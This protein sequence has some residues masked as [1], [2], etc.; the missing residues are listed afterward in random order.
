MKAYAPFSKSVQA[1]ISPKREKLGQGIAVPAE[2]SE[3]TVPEGQ[4]V[5]D[6]AW[7]RMTRSVQRATG[8]DGMLQGCGELM[9]QKKLNVGDQ[10]IQRK[11]TK[12]EVSDQAKLLHEAVDIPNQDEVTEREKTV[13]FQKKYFAALTTP[14]IDVFE[15]A[16]SMTQ[17]YR[18]IGNKIPYKSFL[19]YHT[20]IKKVS[21]FKSGQKEEFENKNKDYQE[22]TDKSQLVEEY[23]NKDFVELTDPFLVQI[24]GQYKGK[25]DAHNLLIL[26]N[27]CEGQKGYIVGVLDSGK[28]FK[29][30][31][32]DEKKDQEILGQGKGISRYYGNIHLI[33]SKKILRKK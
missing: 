14:K 2:K 21:N 29:A 30:E 6:N 19:T 13:K 16:R 7:G 22:K 31:M 32:K 5:A 12:P 18:E 8:V 24:E 23:R 25:G 11:E 33:A 20:L 15:A 3:A 9:V 27:Y 10:A 17:V 1:S 26:V 28:E 4:G